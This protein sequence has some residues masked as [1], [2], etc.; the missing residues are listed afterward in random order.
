MPRTS[1]PLRVHPIVLRRAEVTRVV[2]VTPNMRRLTL[3][4]EDLA[5]GTMGE[6]FERPPFR[7]DGFD[8]HVKL[9]VP[10]QE[11]ALPRI[12]TQEEKRFAWNPEVVSQTRDYTVRSWDPEA[13]TFDI[14]VVRHDHGLAAAWAFRARPGDEIHF[15]GPKSCA[16]R[17]DEAEWHLLAGDETA[18]PAIGRWLEEA[19]E[20]TR[21]HVIVEVPTEA[22]RQDVPTAADV[23]IEWLVRGDAP[24][25]TGTGLFDAVRRVAVPDV[26]VYA[27]V[28]GE[29]M[30]IAPIRRYLRTDL[31]LP[32][33]DV[34]VVGY[35]RRPK[36]DGA[37]D[38]APRDDAER[39]E[40]V[41]ADDEKSPR[42]L[43]EEVH[44]LTELAPPIVTRA[45]VTLGIGPLIAYGVSTLAELGRETGVEPARL[46]V[47]L[48]A[49]AALGLV[50]RDG[51][52][53]RNTARGGV[54][55]EDS[56][57]EELSLDNPANREALA[58]VDLVDVL[59]SGRTSPRLGDPSWRGRRAADPALDSVHQD[60]AADQ[61]QFVL[62]PLTRLAPVASARTLAVVGDAAPFVASRVARGR[63]VHLPGPADA[64]W[65]PHDCAVL[66]GALEGRGDQEALALLRAALSAGPAL[67]L[68][69][70]T[71]DKAATDDHAAEH[72][73]TSLAVT[74]SVLR[75]SA[76]I[77]ELL[78]AAGASRTETTL[79]GWGFG[80]YGTVTV[81]HG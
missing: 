5:A 9:V 17:N 25:G 43:L 58:L 12:G 61:L 37:S 26:R 16:L 30:T 29:A 57:I 3:T 64:A 55:M 78:R 33:E 11:G 46:A 35:W 21:G 54:L 81:A 48:D 39:L 42:E 38:A 40:P 47:L 69:E 13:N 6:G 23:R 74:G 36:T 19:P 66:V 22:D 4:G 15:A 50:E 34:E 53:Y 67:V 7:S 24:A 71:S 56:A 52:R 62:E 41:A 27:W 65:A 20:G 18:L 68:A 63:T 45:A 31:G 73:L 14:D 28:G 72:A 49:M 1:R 32:K 60:R 80:P 2:D 70:R 59:R 44:E 51:D 79:L 10:S 76:R 75:T 77:G 8:D